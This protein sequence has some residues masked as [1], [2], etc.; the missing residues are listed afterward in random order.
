MSALSATL[1]MRP[2][3]WNE[4]L[5]YRHLRM[6]IPLGTCAPRGREYWARLVPYRWRAFHERY[7]TTHGYYWHPCVLCDQPY[8]GHEAG[9]SIPDPIQGERFHIM[10]CSRCTRARHARGE[11]A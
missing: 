2:P 11:K 9:G 6:R 7:A 3:T 4:R 10:I 5:W 8:G 1:T